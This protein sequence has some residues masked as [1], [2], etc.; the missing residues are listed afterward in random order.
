MYVQAVD[1]SGLSWEVKVPD[2]HVRVKVYHVDALAMS[3]VVGAGGQL[4]LGMCFVLNLFSH[5]TLNR[6]LK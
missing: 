6:F 2:H 5:F 3:S 4:A 1:T